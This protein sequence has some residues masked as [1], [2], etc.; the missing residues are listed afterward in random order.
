[1][2]V[3]TGVGDEGN[4]VGVGASVGDEGNGVGVGTSVGD[5]DDG[6]GTGVG[7]GAGWQA[8]ATN[9]TLISTS[10]ILFIVGLS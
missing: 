3:G 6:V 9:S 5:E 4:G 2:G 10:A 7:D 1:V 8:T